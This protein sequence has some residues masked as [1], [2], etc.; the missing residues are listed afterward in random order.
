MGRLK[1]NRIVSALSI[2][3]TPPDRELILKAAQM[4]KM[5]M[6]TWARIKL[7]AAASRAVKL[8]EKKPEPKSKEE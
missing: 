4:A 1:E 8:S 5:S 2:Q 3:F 6:A 7:V